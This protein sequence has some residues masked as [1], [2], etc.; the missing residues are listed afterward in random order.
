MNIRYCAVYE[1]TTQT[2][3]DRYGRVRAI[4]ECDESTTVGEIMTWARSKAVAC[5]MTL[6]LEVLESSPRKGEGEK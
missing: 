6:T 5:S 4:R 2:G 3:I 1:F